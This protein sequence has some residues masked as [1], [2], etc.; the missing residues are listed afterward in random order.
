MLR[1]IGKRL[2]NYLV[3]LYVAVSLTFM[4]AA[5]QLNQRALF[6]L[7]QPPVDPHRALPS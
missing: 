2:L 6:E 7:R 3:L 5:T 4:L 1:Y